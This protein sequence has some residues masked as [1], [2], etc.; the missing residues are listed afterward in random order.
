MADA[1]KQVGLFEEALRYYSPLEQTD[2]H[3]DISFFMAMGDCCERLEKVEDAESCYLM[4]ANHSSKHME[5]RARLA[6]LYE[7]L[8][9]TDQAMKYASEAVLIGRQQNR[10]R[11]KRRKDT[12]LEQ[13]AIEFKMADSEKPR[14]IAP[15]P[16]PAATLMNAVQS[17]ATSHAEG[18]RTE[19][20][21]FLYMKLL[22]LHPLMRECAVDATE[23]WLDIADA[24][25]RDF[26][27]NRAFYPMAQTM[28][29]VGYSKS[30]DPKSE[31][32][33]MMD[34]MQEMANRLQD[35]IGKSKYFSENG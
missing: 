20:I 18:S 7:K 27:S 6:R 21:Q 26:R 28:R 23:D 14:P 34:E 3:A 16:Q 17:G 29:F 30:Q 25:L 2:E 1:L 4:V 35:T 19:D 5:S 22:E 32:G 10:G 13:L 31:D 9:M 33:Q 15:K 11:G 24:L 12:R 8:Q